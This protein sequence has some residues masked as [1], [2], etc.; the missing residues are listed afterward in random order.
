VHSTRVA[1]RKYAAIAAFLSLVLPPA[2]ATA[3]DSR[4]A[5]ITIDNF[6]RISDT[7]YRGSQPSGDDYAKLAELGVRTVIDLQQDYAS[8]EFAR[9]EEAD[10]TRAGMEFVR[11]PMTTRV[12]PTPD[13]IAQFLRI[14]NDPAQQP[15]YVHC[16][17]GKHR[18]G[19]MT[20]VYRMVN[21]QWTADKAY[22]EMKQFKFGWSF[23]H[24]EFKEFVYDYHA[25]LRAGRATAAVAAASQN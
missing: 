6:G 24:P 13:Q 16:K 21:E 22:D 5:A 15:V 14:V 19:V 2:V 25:D 11:I 4:L 10:V 9:T 3:R 8:Q 18:T 1:I 20:A 7:Y 12:V 23:W 17:G